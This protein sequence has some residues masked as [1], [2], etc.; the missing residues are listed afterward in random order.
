MD[1][2]RTHQDA[3]ERLE[4]VGKRFITILALLVLCLVLFSLWVGCDRVET[5]VGTSV[6]AELRALVMN[7]SVDEISGV[8]FV[9]A[10][11]GMPNTLVTSGQVQVPLGSVPRAQVTVQRL[12][13]SPTLATSY[14]TFF[15]P[16]VPQEVAVSVG[17]RRY[18]LEA[19]PL[20]YSQQSD[21]LKAPAVFLY[22]PPIVSTRSNW[23]E[24]GQAGTTVAVELTGFSLTDNRLSIPPAV[25]VA[26]P[27]AGT[28][29]P[30]SSELVV[31]IESTEAMSTVAAITPAV[32]QAS[33]MNASFDTATIVPLV[34][35]AHSLIKEFPRGVTSISFT[36]DELSKLPNGQ[37][38][39][40][41]A[42]A[43]VRLA[44]GG[45]VGLIGQSTVLIPIELRSDAVREGIGFSLVLTRA[46]YRSGDTLS[47]E[48]L[49]QN[50]SGTA[51][52]FNFST[53]CQLGIVLRQDEKPVVSQPKL[54]AQVL[55]S[56][57]IAPS[58][59]KALPFQLP[60]QDLQTRAALPTG[61]YVL[62]A[63]L[64]NGHSPVL[65]QAVR[66]D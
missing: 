25:R 40:S 55:T 58:E 15:E 52:T 20:R 38:L 30:K 10:I 33:R 17:P 64:F 36:P 46:A 45:R 29:V 39:L 23:I 44:N 12:P 31:R 49:I 54:C 11:N 32:A 28:A 3:V 56:L 22:P 8:P 18:R 7:W 26:S 65:R 43:D 35:N 51:Q 21:A 62:E 42:S 48:F 57:A 9:S 34:T 27:V 59:T 60:L 13:S 37:M 14:A 24:L 1:R 50:R 41:V 66:I 47:G 19:M 61:N 53:S 4:I 16:A 5:P 2:V 63:F 6:E